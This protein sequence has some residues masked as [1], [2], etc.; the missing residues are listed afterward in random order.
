MRV[1]GAPEIRALAPAET[2]ARLYVHALNPLAHRN[3]GLDAVTEI[4][5]RVPGFAVAVAEL[6]ASCALIQATVAATLAAAPSEPDFARSKRP[7]RVRP[8]FARA[9]RS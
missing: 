9:K 6:P 5:T 8:D 2:A 4:A 3:W 7:R 1:F